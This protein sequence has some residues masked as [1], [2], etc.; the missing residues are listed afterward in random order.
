MLI[1][2]S[3]HYLY[4][5][6]RLQPIGEKHRPYFL[7][8]APA[9]MDVEE[10]RK[11]VADALRDDE[12]V[13]EIGGVERYQSFWDQR[14]KRE[15]FKVYTTKSYL[16]PEVSDD[17]FRLGLYTAEHDVPY[18]ERALVDLAAAGDWVFDTQG[19]EQKMTVTAYDI[20]MTQY[21]RVREVPIDIIGYYQFDF[22]FRAQKDLDSEDFS[23][24]FIDFPE[25]VEG[26]V[27]QMVASDAE[28][29][30]DILLKMCDILQ[31]SD[32]I[33][34]HNIIGF[35]NLQIYERIRSILKNAATLSDREAQRFRTFLDTYARRDQSYHFG[36]PQTTAIFY[37]ASFDTLQ[38][39]RKFYTLDSYSLS[40]TAEFLGVDIPGR[41]DLDPEA[42]ALDERTFQYNRE[43]VREQAAIALY[44]LQQALPLAFTTGMPFELLLPSGATKMWDFMA[45][46]RAAKHKK[47]VPAT[48]RALSVASAVS[49]MGATKQEIAQAARSNAD[50]EV[51]RVAKYGE[52]M[53]DW[54]EY[55]FL[56]YDQR[57]KGIAYHFPG[58]MTIK[59]DRDANS[60]FVPW[61]H[62][63]VADVGAMYP[64]ILKAV[65]A[66]ADT[67]RL[68]RKDEE[69][70]DWVWLKK[71][72]DRFLHL[73]VK[74]RE[75]T[76]DFVDKGL[77]IGIKIAPQ[78]GLVNL[79]MTGILN[80]INKTKSDM[81]QAVGE[82]KHR[83][84]MMYQSLKGARNAGTHG[85][86]SAPRV[87]C[88]QFNLWGAALI[89]TKGQQILSDTLR[90]LNGRG[91]RVVY[92]D[93]DGIYVATSR[94]ASPQLAT[95]LG[96]DPPPESWI[97]QP[98]E[99]LKAIQ[100]CNH[101]WR[102]EL[103]YPEFELEP[104]E[105]EAMIFVKHKNY[106][107]FD[108]A[109]G[110]V[111]M[112]TKG[113]NFKGSDKPDIARMVLKDIMV[114]VLRENASWQSEEE[115]RRN[116]KTSIKKITAD[117]VANLDIERFDLDAFTLVQSVAPPG[118]YKPNPNGSDSV[119]C[120]RAKALEKLV[121][122]ITARRKF[123]F[124]ITKQ[125]LPGIPNPT[126]SGVK[127]IHYMYPVELL[128]SR[129]QIDL[130]WY[131]DMIINFVKGAFGLPDLDLK[132]QYGL[133]T[134]M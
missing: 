72:P 27:Q 134:W 48:C 63:V 66:G 25:R 2:V 106:L 96:V 34:G 24:Q 31:Q 51:L 54:V 14:V 109:D 44:L 122:R 80:V 42:L 30:I 10:A 26:E 123:R 40:S 11:K 132:E 69:A 104:E 102:E 15:V 129:R 133:D 58:G 105:H 35:D 68:A 73:D 70:D 38:A 100:H 119:Y 71:V 75:A 50:K 59:P 111:E 13:E 49:T 131:T 7:V 29:E 88:R 117:T 4:W 93:T 62:V 121:G 115:A 52:E 19:D 60:H 74:T 45:M 78:P 33:T 94:A 95:A 79:A 56:L 46:I 47:I 21:G 81:K 82:E 120:Q 127:P 116:I 130:E 77:M 87:S 36:T 43:D 125:P 12:R 39:A 86:L 23:F 89:T 114:D 1:N 55:P 5:K 61:Y 53:P 17:V 126:K 85:I 41:L 83:L 20:E 101:K 65:N 113:N 6:D 99:A 124:V 76:E 92:G 108:V 37:P 16:V 98:Q 112:T 8:F 28:E 97:I 32:I 118:R 18:H 9:G 57:T 64:T 110:Q 103:N 22:S 67:V 84:A 3:P 91:A 107:I 90:I 128:Q